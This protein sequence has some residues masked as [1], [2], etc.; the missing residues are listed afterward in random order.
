MDPWGVGVHWRAAC[1]AA[2]KHP[3]T[4]QKNLINLFI[5]VVSNRSSEYY[6]MRNRF[7]KIFFIYKKQ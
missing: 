6:T 2:A 7:W 3:M 4:I 1:R 5:C